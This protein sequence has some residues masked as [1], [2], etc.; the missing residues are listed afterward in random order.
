MT[1]EFILNRWL[2]EHYL[3]KRIAGPPWDPAPFTV[4]KVY[5]DQDCDHVSVWFW[6]DRKRMDGATTGYSVAMNA[7]LPEVVP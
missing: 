1:A 7:E 5:W 2:E 4:T 3:G 6:S